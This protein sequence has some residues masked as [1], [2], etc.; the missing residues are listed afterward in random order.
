MTQGEA[1]QAL[2]SQAPPNLAIICGQGDF[3]L[4]AA[5]SAARQGCNVLMI[6]VRGVASARIEAYPHVWLGL[7][8]LGALFKCL[9]QRSIRRLAVAGGMT[10]PA[11]REIRMDF[12][13]LKRLP[14]IARLFLGGDNH[15]LSGLIG[16]IENEGVAVVGIDAIAPEL[17]A[18]AGLATRNAP[19][20]QADADLALGRSFI[21]AAS[22][23][24]VGQAVVTAG[25]RILAVE[26]AEGT[27]A[28][29][30]RIAA[31]RSS[32]RLRLKGRAGVLV[33][34]PKRGQDLRN[35]LPAI[36]PRTIELAAAAELEGVSLAAGKVLVLDQSE[37][38]RQ[39][40]AAGLFLQG[41]TTD[42]EAP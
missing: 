36:G 12:G 9:R 26:A 3:P 15:L 16:L 35:D 33:K 22:P 38:A 41:Y 37:L 24:D 34:A 27:D 40:D 28:M 8:E 21:D 23:F 31:L 11:L 2:S 4:R 5:E 10:R 29:L 19:N 6:G 42:A 30:E 17:L 1:A 18:Q 13:G 20:K 32:G 7:G 25:G 39:A 14:A